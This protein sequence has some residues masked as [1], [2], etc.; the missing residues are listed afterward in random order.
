VEAST[1]TAAR[2]KGREIVRRM[3]RS[4]AETPLRRGRR[5]GAATAANICEGWVW[6]VKGVGVGGRRGR[7]RGVR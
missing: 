1:A 7:E 2:A 4:E 3:R 5:S 6:A